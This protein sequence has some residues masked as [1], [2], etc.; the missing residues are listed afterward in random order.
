[1]LVP[2]TFRYVSLDSQASGFRTSWSLTRPVTRW[3]H[4]Y[5]TRS[6]VIP[7]TSFNSSRLKSTPTFANRP[8]SEGWHMATTNR[9]DPFMSMSLYIWRYRGSKMFR[10]CSLLGV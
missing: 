7:L 8:S 10:T 1:M 5:F 2:L 6:A 9:F 4:M 3:L